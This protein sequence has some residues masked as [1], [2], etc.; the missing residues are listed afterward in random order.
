MVALFLDFCHKYRH[1]YLDELS[2]RLFTEKLK[3][4][5]QQTFQIKEASEVVRLYYR[6][7]GAAKDA[8]PLSA[9]EPKTAS[10]Q[11]PSATQ[12]EASS[13]RDKLTKLRKEIRVRHYS[14]KT[15]SSYYGWARKEHRSP[16]DFQKYIYAWMTGDSQQSFVLH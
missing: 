1:G 14:A 8:L 16:L 2:L 12:P 5:G 15:L 11:P 7:A 10:N 13:W 6:M 9:G 3:D 4:K